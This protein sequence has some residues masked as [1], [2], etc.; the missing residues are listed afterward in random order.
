MQERGCT[1]KTL[2]GKCR[3]CGQGLLTAACDGFEFFEDGGF[4]FCCHCGSNH[5]EVTTAEGETIKQG[6]RKHTPGPWQVAPAFLDQVYSLPEFTKARIQEPEANPYD[7]ALICETGGN[8][9]N[10]RLIAAAPELLEALQMLLDET[11]AGTWDCLPI[12]KA[13]AAIAKATKPYAGH[14]RNGDT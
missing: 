12:D 10:A 6:C 1:M 11:N 8:E 2:T 4:W 13:R 3:D 5:V 14:K 7:E 9:A